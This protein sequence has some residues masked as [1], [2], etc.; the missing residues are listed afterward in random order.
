MLV[1]NASHVNLTK[2]SES[3]LDISVLKQIKRNF[4]EARNKVLMALIKF[5]RVDIFYS[6]LMTLIRFYRSRQGFD[7][8]NQIWSEIGPRLNWAQEIISISRYKI[9][10]SLKVENV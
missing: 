9:L 4:T 3:K 10:E 6:V 5:V 1:R 7:D 8:R 2:I